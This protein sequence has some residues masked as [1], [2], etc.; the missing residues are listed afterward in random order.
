MRLVLQVTKSTPLKLSKDSIKTTTQGS[1]S[2]GLKVPKP[3]SG[4]GKLTL[5][6]PKLKQPPPR[7]LLL[8]MTDIQQIYSGLTTLL[9]LAWIL[10]HIYA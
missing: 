10:K 8:P 6:K 3:S 4:D 9:A 2:P 1:L 5:V 7:K